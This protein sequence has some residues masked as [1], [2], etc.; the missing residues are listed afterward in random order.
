MSMMPEIH[1][2]LNQWKTKRSWTVEPADWYRVYS[3]PTSYTISVKQTCHMWS[4]PWLRA[5]Y[6][7]RGHPKGRFWMCWE[8][9]CCTVISITVCL[10]CVWWQ[11]VNNCVICILCLHQHMPL[12]SRD[13]VNVSMP[14]VSGRCQ[15]MHKI[16]E[17]SGETHKNRLP[18]FSC[19][20][21]HCLHVLFLQNCFSLFRFA[22]GCSVLFVIVGSLRKGV[23]KIV[24]CLQKQ[25]CCKLN[26]S[27]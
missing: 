6:C 1:P 14:E 21:C 7:S 25:H 12:Y 22:W 23:E 24:I 18:I 13:I 2:V 3:S 10:A 17:Q 8:T 15:T 5:T 9:L 27:L 20:Q 4:Q 19:W 16:E 11:R 26:A